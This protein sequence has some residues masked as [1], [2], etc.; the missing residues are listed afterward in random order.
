MLG[1]KFKFSRALTGIVLFVK[2][3]SFSHRI[4]L[5]HRKIAPACEMD[6]T[7]DKN[8]KEERCLIKYQLINNRVSVY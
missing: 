7:L 6:K 3:D 4:E 5:Y 8:V 1:T 2:C